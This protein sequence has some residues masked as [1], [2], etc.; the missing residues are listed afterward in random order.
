MILLIYAVKTMIISGLLYIYYWLFLR[1][2][3]FHLYNRF[4]LIGIPCIALILPLMTIS[5]PCLNWGSTGQGAARLLQ[6]TQGRWED[7]V[8]VRPSLNKIGGNLNLLASLFFIYY[9]LVIAFLLVFLRSAF[10]IFRISKSYPYQKMGGARF[11]ETDEKGTPFSFFNLVFWNRALDF[12]SQKGQQVL[13]HELYHVQQR[14]SFDIVFL[15]FLRIFFWFNPF[16]LLI[17]KEI[18]AIHEFLADQ[19][20]VSGHNKYA[21]AEILLL[22]SMQ[23]EH[24]QIS[25]PFFHN[26]IKRR[27]A[28]ITKNKSIQKSYLS[29][30]MILPLLLF[31][32]IV[33]AFRFIPKE[34]FSSSKRIKAIVDAGHGGAD[35]GAIAANGADEKSI[36]LQIAQKIKTLSKD[37]PI[38]I[39][40]TREADELAG[41]T[42]DMHESLKY[43]ASLASK[44]H[45]DLFI[46][47]HVNA[48]PKDPSANGFDVYVSDQNPNSKS[49]L[50]GTLITESL[51]KEYQVS[52][53]L[54]KSD[55]VLVLHDN[56]VPAVLVECGYLTNTKD[57]VM[58]SNE[59]NQE[60]IAKDILAG[61]LKYS[62]T[63]PGS[64]EGNGPPPVQRTFEEMSSPSPTK[65]MDPQE[66]IFTKVEVEAEYPGGKQAWLNYLNSHL[67][68]PQKAIDKELMGDVVVEF[69]VDK[70]GNISHVKALSGPQELRPESV[71]IIKESGKWIPAIQAGQ[72][73][74]AYR[75]QPI[76]YRLERQ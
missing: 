69:V 6:V 36:N 45:A 38:E 4:F 37:Y 39:I 53:D 60:K 57:Q 75:K 10:Y 16:F 47:I 40:L 23:P 63:N 55:R 49:I 61:I 11:Y 54:K 70:S 44:L 67:V 51:G 27:I 42:T 65:Q 21:Y 25:N 76:K 30:L 33:F 52:N 41:K 5:F 74:N 66:K 17:R 20:A 8:I 15:E 19:Y 22:S 58:I 31:L 12:K 56:N 28:M 34:T 43:R 46:S 18:N 14:H 24:P 50:L 7:A 68:Y 2:K 48:D 59:Q 3:Q 64:Q 35:M 26:Q 62:Q 1:N 32:S 13:R 73:V 9:A 71:R 29:R 72:K